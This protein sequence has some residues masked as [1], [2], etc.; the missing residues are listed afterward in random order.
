MNAREKLEECK[1]I[2][3]KYYEP[4]HEELAALAERL[5]DAIEQHLSMIAYEGEGAPPFDIRVQQACVVLQRMLE[6]NDE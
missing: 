2:G 5:L 1:R 3:R 6:G 4:P